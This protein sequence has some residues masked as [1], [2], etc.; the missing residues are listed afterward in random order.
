MSYKTYA[1]L[2]KSEDS[3]TKNLNIKSE[4][5]QNTTE[6]FVMPKKHKKAVFNL[7]S[8]EHL[9]KL[10]K[11]H[12]VVIVDTWAEW[13]GP[14]KRIAPEFENLARQHQKNKDILFVKD[15]IDND[16]SPHRNDV[17]AIPTFFFYL[18]G[19]KQ[20]KLIY[21]GADISYVEKNLN[22]IIEFCKKNP[23]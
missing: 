8:K 18:E 9:D 23:K 4:K 21:T 11:K 15:N 6:Q 12:R 22:K 3:K 5:I 2:G 10:L 7:E 20:E 19:K 16:D 13:C 17:N 14:C 1:D